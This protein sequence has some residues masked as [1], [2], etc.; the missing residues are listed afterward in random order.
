M[1]KN[2]NKLIDKHILI[3]EDDWK[4]I[5]K[6][7]Q[8]NVII[9]SI[10][11]VIHIAIDN[12]EKTNKEVNKDDLILEKLEKVLLQLSAT[13][14]NV[15]LGNELIGE[16]CYLKDLQFVR[17][18]VSKNLEETAMKIV[19]KKIKNAQERKAYRK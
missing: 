11:D 12:L 14:K 2:Q 19:D 4:T 3:R 1:N 15:E 8:E 5:E 7:K 17:H 18:G 10:A 13:D 16:L 9:N 6:I